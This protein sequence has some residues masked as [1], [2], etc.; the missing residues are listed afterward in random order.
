MSDDSNQ[1]V[2]IFSR[3]LEL[4]EE[5]RAAYLAQACGC[6]EALRLLVEGLLRAHIKS[7]GFMEEAP[8]T[9][10]MMGFDGASCRRVFRE[11]GGRGTKL[12]RSHWPLQ[13]APTDR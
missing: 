9:L 2:V 7:A 10:E 6:D 4:P 11:Q 5:K 12:G 13:V 1:E 3:S 8:I